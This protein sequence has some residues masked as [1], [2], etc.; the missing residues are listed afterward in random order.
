[1][2]ILVIGTPLLTPVTDI[3]QD[4]RQL[5]LAMDKL[6]D[7]KLRVCSRLR[8]ETGVCLPSQTAIR[9]MQSAYALARRLIVGQPEA[10]RNETRPVE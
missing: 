10:L 6:P 2:D 5:F 9:S 7:M 8:C 3:A 1:M 4:I